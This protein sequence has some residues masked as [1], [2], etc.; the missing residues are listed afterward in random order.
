VRLLKYSQV[1]ERAITALSSYVS[2]Q[3][4]KNTI[5]LAKKYH[6]VD[7]LRTAYQKLV[8]QPSLSIPDL[9][10]PEPLDWETTA[11]I[12]FLRQTLRPNLLPGRSY[13]YCPNCG[14]S[15]SSGSICSNCFPTST[16]SSSTLDEIFGE[17]LEWMKKQSN[18]SQVDP[19]LPCTWIFGFYRFVIDANAESNPRRRKNRSNPLSWKEEEKEGKI[20]SH[21]T[22]SMILGIIPRRRVCRWNIIASALSTVL[23]TKKSFILEYV[24][25][26]YVKCTDYC[27]TFINLV[28]S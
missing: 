18:P 10:G 11:K 7:W 13:Y 4:P 6:V 28:F 23:Q 16:S 19:P 17:E 20:T 14:N 1:R 3:T 22:G 21:V 2:N 12:F 5:L 24:P 27:A 9:T 25:S 15:F 8:Q 26:I